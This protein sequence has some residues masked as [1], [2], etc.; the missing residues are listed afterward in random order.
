MDLEEQQSLLR[1]HMLRDKRERLDGI[2]ER[3]ESHAKQLQQE[4]T[5]CPKERAVGKLLLGLDVGTTGAKAF[6]YDESGQCLSFA[7]E[8]LNTIRD[9]PGKEELE[10]QN[11]WETVL[12]VI[13]EAMS[14]ASLK[15][16]EIWAMGITTQRNTM[17]LWDKQ[18]GQ[19]LCNFITWQDMR[20]SE[21]CRQLN[22]SLSCRSLRCAARLALKMKGNLKYAMAQHFRFHPTHVTPRL[23]WALQRLSKTE[24]QKLLNE[25]R[26]LFGLMDSYLIWKL[27]GGAI[28]ATD[29]SNISSTGLWDMF[30]MKWNISATNIC[31]IPLSI[32]PE[33]RSSLG[34]FGE[35]I[36]DLFGA[37]IPIKLERAHLTT[38]GRINPT[39]STLLSILKGQTVRTKVL[40]CLVSAAFPLAIPRSLQALDASLTL[41][42][43]MLRLALPR[44][45]FPLLR[46]R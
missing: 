9:E 41:T 44:G 34:D 2:I 30:D 37:P 15:A 39:D 7:H 40:L 31:R 20:T 29:H 18:T 46:G 6:I 25:R 8:N 43:G 1:L 13:E 42:L 33:L 17:I 26:M 3:M 11:L 23:V 27:T 38:M 36:P 14:K 45:Y 21:L 10:P 24:R 28:H 35:V 16:G 12:M 4:K 22:H 19:P 5:L 32:M